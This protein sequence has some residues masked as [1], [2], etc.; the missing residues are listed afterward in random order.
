MDNF[1]DNTNASYD[2]LAKRILSR[3]VILARILKTCVVEFADCPLDDIMNKYIEGDPTATI[4][5]F[6]LDDILDIRGRNTEFNSPNEKS[7]KLDIIFDAITPSTGEPIQIIINIEPQKTDSVDY[8]IIKRAIYYA[9]RLISSQKEK[10]FSGDDY[11]KIRKVYSI[12][13]V[14]DVHKDRRNSIQR[15]KVTEEL[16]HGTFHEDIKNYDLMTIV[17]LNLGYGTMSHDL[18]KMLHLIFLDL[19]KTEQKEAILLD[20][21]GIKLTRD[22]R[23]EIDRMGGLMQPAVDMAVKKIVNETVK[24]AVT[25]TET[26]ARKDERLSSIRNLMKNMKWTAQQAMEAIGIP[27]EEQPKYAAL[28]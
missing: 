14:M 4:D 27:Q 19:L 8:L 2:V 13:V 22:M 5:T 24:K 15:F 3:K 1:M 10:I 6:P 11:N 28:I 21:Y 17:L 16:L 7:V 23:E 9:A 20:D 18:L 26:N 12:W 25:E